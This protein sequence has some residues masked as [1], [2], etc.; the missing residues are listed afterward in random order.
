MNAQDMPP[1]EPDMLK[2]VFGGLLQTKQY[3]IDEI[4]HWGSPSMNPSKMWDD[5]VRAGRIRQSGFMLAP[6]WP[7][8]SLDGQMPRRRP[9]D[10]PLTDSKPP[11]PADFREDQA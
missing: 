9:H 6:D 1:K 10:A 2:R 8:Y 5:A 4:I 11:H 3:V 7:L